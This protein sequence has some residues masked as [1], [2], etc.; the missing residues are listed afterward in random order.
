M[1]RTASEPPNASAGGEDWRPPP[2][3]EFTD[4]ERALLAG[5][6]SN[7]DQP[8]FAIS[9]PLQVDRGALMSRYS[10]SGRGMRRIFLDEFLRDE[11]RGERFYERVL[12][13]YGDD[14]VAEL[15]AAQ[16][17]VE[18]ISNIAV[19][20]VE[21]R[22]IGLSFLEKSSRYVA[23]AE[24]RG[25]HYM[26]YRGADLMESRFGDAYAAACDLAFSTYAGALDPMIKYVREV[27]PIEGRSFADSA[28]GGESVPYDS[29]RD[30]ASIRSA[31][32]VYRSTTRAKALDVL[33]GLLPASALTNVGITGNGRAFEYLLAH[34]NASPLA[35]ERSV[36]RMMKAE[37]DSVVGPFVKRAGGDTRHGRALVGY[38]EGV[39]DVRRGARSLLGRAGATAPPRGSGGGARAP[40]RARLVGWDEQDDALDWIVAALACGGP[41]PVRYADALDAARA[42]PREAKVAIVKRCADLRRNRR[43]RPPRAFEMAAYTFDVVSNFGMF[44][45]IHRHRMLTMER[46]LLTADYGYEV[47]P[48]AEAA[49]AGRAYAECLDA[50]RDVFER[51]RASMPHEAQYVVN[52]GYNYPYMMRMNLREATHLIELRTVPQ[53]HTDY[54]GLLQ[55]MYRQVREKHP[56]LAV[57]MRH[58]DMGQ[59]DLA[60]LESEK[61]VARRVREAGMAPAAGREG[62]GRIRAGDPGS[63]TPEEYRVC[64]EGATEPPFTGRYHDCKDAGTYRCACCGAALFESG[65]KFDS[66]T[67]WPSFWRPSSDSS[68]GSSQDASHGMLRTEA[69]CARCGAHLGHVFDD[70]PRPTGLRYCINSA[71]LR[72]ERAEAPAGGGAGTGSP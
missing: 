47:P 19:K 46:S 71:S 67:G 14:S 38:L 26:Y 53:G 37:L 54:R 7:T 36:S 66:G 11:K 16:I 1:S 8:V 56:D 5:H 43:H 13:E 17:A 25:G 34:L 41:D 31:E 21:D 68:V 57:I 63:L 50:S 70:G 32:S 44:R 62:G 20:K 51:M 35:E 69:S 6:F 40:S 15:G 12:V 65:A 10:R 58:V 18:G 27:H 28:S 23:W 30:E 52:F 72:L 48:E 61:R 42:A 24:K 64:V 39:R 29:M 33:R 55:S 60:R 45:D 4:G 59:Y 22:R 3:D 2:V 9:T 49:G